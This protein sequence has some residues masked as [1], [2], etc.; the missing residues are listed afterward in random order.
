MK[1]AAFPRFQD[2]QR[3]RDAK[4]LSLSATSNFLLCSQSL[5]PSVSFRPNMCIMSTLMPMPSILSGSQK[6]KTWQ[7]KFP[8]AR[9]MW[10]KMANFDPLRPQLGPFW[11][12]GLKQSSF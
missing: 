11:S 5:W 12:I 1:I 10:T 2:R 4:S 3:F 6:K 8:L 9:Q 7:K